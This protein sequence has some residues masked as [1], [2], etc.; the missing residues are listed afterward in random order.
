MKSEVIVVGYGPAAMTTSA[1]L[2]RQSI[3]TTIVNPFPVCHK[4]PSAT[5]L[6]ALSLSSIELFKE[7][8]LVKNIKSIGQPIKKIHV[9]QYKRSGLLEF[10]PT[11]IHEENFGYMVDEEELWNSLHSD[12]RDTSTINE[13]HSDVE[14]IDCQNNKI[15]LKL[16]SGQNLTADLL[17][18]ADGKNSIIRKKLHFEVEKKSYNQIVLICDVKHSKN[19]QGV[20]REVFMKNGPFA[21][22]P[23]LGGYSSSVVWT[24]SM[25]SESFLRSLNKDFLHEFIALRCSKELGEIKLD[26]NPSLF[27]LSFTYSKEVIAERIALVGDAWHAIHPL[28]GQGL[29]L[30]LRDIK[31]LT[32]LIVKE[33][34]IGLDIG[35]FQVL[36]KYRRVRRDDITILISTIDI[37]NNIYKSKLPIVPEIGQFMIRAVSFCKP[38]RNLFM[39]YASG[40]HI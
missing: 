18:A 32:D 2:G 35:N 22:L 13:V 29:N 30:G 31:A 11:D 40:K 20:T 33:K 3:A 34:S 27:P 4:M 21:T 9:S 6:L 7:H 23:K 14:T 5:R 19:H 38:L 26:S 8:K 25:A 37:I 39:I 24:E 15:V 12:V 16:S 10:D 1:I 36:K 17:I 28:A